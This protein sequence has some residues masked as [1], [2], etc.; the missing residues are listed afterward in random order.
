MTY[1]LSHLTQ[2]TRRVYGPIQDDEALLLYAI[3]KCM[4]ITAVLEVGGQTGYSARNF[5]AAGA[6]VVT[7]DIDPVPTL[8]PRHRVIQA[9]AATASLD[10]IPRC[11]LVFFDAHDEAAQWRFYERAVDAE[12]IDDDT[13]LAV[14]DTG[15]HAE[16]FVWWS[17]P[18]G[19]G[20]AHQPAERRFVERLRAAGWAAIH[21][22]DDFAAEPRHG[23]TIL[24]K[25]RSLA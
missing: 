21:A 18:C 5:L 9:N 25:P 16:K 2:D 3:V 11:G 4:G 7:I 17:V 20:W 1:D 24:Q 13:A 14:H 6:E 23:L 12:V 15:L 10:G 8:S 19:A 22:H